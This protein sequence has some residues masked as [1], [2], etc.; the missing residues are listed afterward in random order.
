MLQVLAGAMD[1]VILILL[2]AGIPLL[3]LAFPPLQS[4]S[5]TYLPLRALC[6]Q[7]GGWVLGFA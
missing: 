1:T 6:I 2:Q 5:S 7:N 3:S 4:L